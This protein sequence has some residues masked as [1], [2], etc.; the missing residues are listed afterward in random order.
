[1]NWISELSARI[2]REYPPMRLQQCVPLAEHTS[3]RIGGPAAL[4]AS[5]TTP[6]ELAALCTAAAALRVRTVILG[7]GTNVLAPDEGLD[8]LVILT[9][10][11][12][13]AIVMEN[14]ILRAGCGTT[15][16]QAALYAQSHGYKGLEFAHGI[17]GTVGGGVLMN[18]GAYGGEMRDVVRQVRALLPDGTIG[19]FSGAALQFGYRQSVFQKNA[20]VILEV[21]FS[22]ESDEPA[23]ILERMQVLR[24][25]RAASQPLEYPS[26]G[27][28]F[29]RPQIGYAAALIDQAGL[30]GLQ[31][32]GA[33]VSE[34]HAGFVINRG[35]ATAAD[36]KQLMAEVQCR[37]FAKSGVQLEPEVLML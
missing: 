15:L 35:G 32:G 11:G 19:N 20:A 26:A 3:F 16:A 31:I 33:Q 1:M 25:K 23:A 30:K 9:K 17:P 10:P 14:G 27:S 29:K 22:L 21:E 5:P 7:A 24:A 8:A 2:Q 6:E 12:L 34:K 13:S 36:V 28:T 18:A 4:M 37:V